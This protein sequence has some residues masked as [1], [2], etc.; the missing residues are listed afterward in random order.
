VAVYDAI[1]HK[2]ETSPAGLP[3]HQCRP[4]TL[5][6]PRRRVTALH[7]AGI[8]AYTNELFP[9]YQLL[10]QKPAADGSH[11]GGMRKK[12]AFSKYLLL[13]KASCL[14]RKSPTRVRQDR[15]GA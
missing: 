6:G 10:P 3:L 5:R 13:A 2:G 4:R 7:D 12:E 15:G 1:G 9:S 11:L 14:G 8:F